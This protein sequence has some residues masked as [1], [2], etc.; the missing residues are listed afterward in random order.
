VF[1]EFIQFAASHDTALG[2]STINDGDGDPG[3][4]SLAAR[5]E[6]TNLNIWLD[7]QRGPTVGGSVATYN[8]DSFRI[9]GNWDHIVNL[10][11][12]LIGQDQKGFDVYEQAHAWVMG[13]WTPGEG[14][15]H[16]LTVTFEPIGCGRVMYSTYHT[17]D[18]SH[19]GLVPQERILLYLIM[20]I[21]ECKSGPI[22]E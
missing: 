18:F 3:Y 5:A 9:D 20:E 17:T 21:G 12:I 6:D 4:E 19:P 13:D 22:V 10:P 14:P 16:P 11:S 1:P 7:G 2:D 8:A 15:I